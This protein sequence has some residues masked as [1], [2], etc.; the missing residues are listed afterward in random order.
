MSNCQPDI[1][2]N[3]RVYH[4]ILTSYVTREKKETRQQTLCERV[5]PVFVRVKVVCALW[6]WN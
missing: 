2:T 6:L 4:K 1:H 5:M 3:V